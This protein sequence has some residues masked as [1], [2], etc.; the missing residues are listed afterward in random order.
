MSPRWSFRDNGSVKPSFTTVIS[1]LDDLLARYWELPVESG[2]WCEYRHDPTLTMRMQAALDRFSPPNSTYPRDWDKSAGTDG[3]ARAVQALRED[4]A[5]G[6]LTTLA[7]IIH[8][9][10]FSDMLE[11]ADHLLTEGY[12]DPAAVM[13]GGVLEQ[14]L[15]ELCTRHGI[16]V[17]DQKGEPRRAS[18]QNQYLKAKGV[19][20][21]QELHEVTAWLGLRN[22]AA[23]G[24]YEKF[25]GQ[26]VKLMLEGVRHFLS[27]FP[28]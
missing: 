7:E 12:K 9:E 5:S 23:H 26:Q 27:R 19:Y 17:M 10:L 13:V 24:L 1:Q 28:A 15:R 25:T 20:G 3:V 11:A 16:P 14:H 18:Q 6:Y 8:A 22:D 4:Y 2:D 21:K